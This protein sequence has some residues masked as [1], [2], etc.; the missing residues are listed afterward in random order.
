MEIHPV[1]VKQGMDL[2]LPISQM[3]KASLREVGRLACQEIF[4]SGPLASQ[5]GVLSPRQPHHGLLVFTPRK[6]QELGQELGQRGGHWGPGLDPKFLFI[7]FVPET[8]T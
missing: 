6:I 5:S 3:E 4:S 8:A 1:L 2:N 7:V